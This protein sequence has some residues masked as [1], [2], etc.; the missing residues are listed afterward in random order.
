ME[1]VESESPRNKPAWLVWVALAG[2]ALLLGLLVLVLAAIFVVPNVL[3]K[4]AVAST[5]KAESDLV[6]LESALQ[7]YSLVNG[8]K[9]PDTLQALVTPDM[10]GHTFL[11]GPRVPKDPWGN[12]YLYD[13]PEPGRPEARVYTY[14]KDGLAGGKGDDAD[15]DNF[16]IRARR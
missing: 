2:G 4:F 13:P 10:N 9:Y 1:A 12:E 11:K 15:L 7:E 14:G 6:Q 3:Q 5:S 16:S 8:G